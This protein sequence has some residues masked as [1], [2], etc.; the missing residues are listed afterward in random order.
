MNVVR[1]LCALLPRIYRCTHI[2]TC[3][4]CQAPLSTRALWIY[5]LQYEIYP[6]VV[7]VALWA[8]VYL[9][10][11][12]VYNTCTYMCACACACEWRFFQHF[13][14]L[15]NC[16]FYSYYALVHIASTS[17]SGLGLLASEW[18][19][20]YACC[21]KHCCICAWLYV[22]LYAARQKLCNAVNWLKLDFL[23]LYVI[24]THTSKRI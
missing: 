4:C 6:F 14:R 24:S 9:T 16:N 2:Y 17:L 8:K 23:C 7:C 18:P 11:Q 10:Y 20:A 22:F 21:C 1:K 19:N 15:S 13:L 3:I 12:R 5:V